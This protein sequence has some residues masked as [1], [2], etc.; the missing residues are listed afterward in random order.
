MRKL[1][2]SGGARTRLVRSAALAVAAVAVGLHVQAPAARAAAAV[3]RWVAI[4]R[5]ETALADYG[6][7][8]DGPVVLLFPRADAWEARPV[9]SQAV[10]AYRY[11]TR[12]LGS[13]P[14]PPVLLVLEPDS[15]AMRRMV[16]AEAASAV[17]A[18]ASGV[19]Y[20]LAPS[21]W[22]PGR[23]RILWQEFAREGPVADELSHLVLDEQAPGNVPAWYSE[24]VAQLVAWKYQGFVWRVPGGVTYSYRQ[25]SGPFYTLPNLAGAYREA[26]GIVQEL[27]GRAGGFSALRAVD[28]R[29]AQGVPFPQAVR[30]VTGRSPREWWRAWR[31]AAR[32]GAGEG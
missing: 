3:A 4:R 13:R 8:Q 27:A 11:V 26:M 6:R 17:G 16:G 2:R 25:L 1:D 19:V 12:V 21:A 14:A 9:L 20:L 22:L 7:V 10:G 28:R 32:E 29:L 5:T 23:G 24:G 18:Y 31:R 15:R 30:G